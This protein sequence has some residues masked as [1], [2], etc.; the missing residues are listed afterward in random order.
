M[1]GEEN[2][3]EVLNIPEAE[4][5]SADNEDISLTEEIS[6]ETAPENNEEIEIPDNITAVHNP[7]LPDIDDAADISDE[8]VMQD[9][10]EEI[11]DISQ[12]EMLDE[13]PDFPEVDDISTDEMQDSQD[14]ENIQAQETENIEELSDENSIN[15]TSSEEMQEVS[16]NTPA[17]T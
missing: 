6:E 3:E 11:D 14:I 17:K 15:E 1:W 4:E 9:N 2:N 13:F 10:L 5:N 16:D 12:N 8:Y 7:V